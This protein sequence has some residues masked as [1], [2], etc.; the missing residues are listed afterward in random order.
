[1]TRVLLVFSNRLFGR[2]VELLLRQETSLDLWTCE[3]DMDRVIERVET[4]QP[5][6]VVIDRRARQVDVE[7]GVSRL[8]C[9]RED[10]A[11]IHLHPDD[12]TIYV[13]GQPMVIG[14]VRDLVEA[15]E[16]SARP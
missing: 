15:I 4:L 2:G 11:V 13:S 14:Q 5:D 8:L 16:R 12:N 9:A 10:L 6:V 3:Q 7:D 1:M